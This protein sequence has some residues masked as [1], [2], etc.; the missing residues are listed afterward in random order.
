MNN[1]REHITVCIC[2]YKREHLLTHVLN[3]L[4]SQITEDRF[5]FSI[6]VVDNDHVQSGKKVVSDFVQVARV[7]TRYCNESRQNIS[8]A[9]NKAIENATGDYIAFLDDDEVPT[10]KWLLNLFNACQKYGADGVLGSAKPDFEGKPP[11]WV[12]RGKF[13]ERAA[14]PTGFVIHWRMGRTGNVLL[15]GRLFGDGEQAFKPELRSGE[16]QDFFRRMIEKGHIFIWCNEA[17]TNEIIPAVRCNRTYILNRALLNGK[18]KLTD[19]RIR[20]LDI[21]KS[22]VAVMVYT[23]ALPFLLL[24][25]QHVFMRYMVKIYNHVSRLLVFVGVDPIKDQRTAEL[26]PVSAQGAADRPVQ[27]SISTH[28]SSS[29]SRSD[30]ALEN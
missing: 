25:G 24:L 21:L 12:V 27:R 19:S 13:F 2:T 6:I 20:Y 22:T 1:P 28:D 17:V 10:D 4:N 11:E 18:Y 7:P 16:D 26:Y 15:K 29:R 14:H 8:L 3:G 9:R 30:V 23:I 5:T